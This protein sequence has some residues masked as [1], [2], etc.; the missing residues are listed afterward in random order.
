LLDLAEER[1]LVLDICLRG[2][3]ST[4]S[5]IREPG[6]KV[7]DAP[8]ER[9]TANIAELVDADPDFAFAAGKRPSPSRTTA[10]LA[11]VYERTDDSGVA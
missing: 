9:L 10:C 1:G 8:K 7:S 11:F 3:A 6:C 2:T 5:S 4:A